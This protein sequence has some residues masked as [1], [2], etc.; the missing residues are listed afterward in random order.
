VIFGGKS[1]FIPGKNGSKRIG[2]TL[3]HFAWNHQDEELHRAVKKYA[4]Y[5]KEIGIEKSTGGYGRK[6]LRKPTGAWHYSLSDQARPFLLKRKS[7]HKKPI[8][9]EL[10]A[11][12]SDSKAASFR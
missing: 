3:G 1:D 2:G 6:C 8:R 11:R 7:C 4:R 12:P 9:N 5:S 10:L